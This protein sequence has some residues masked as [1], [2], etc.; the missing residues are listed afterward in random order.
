VIDSKP[1]HENNASA[2]EHKAAL[3]V[4]RIFTRVAHR[5]PRLKF[6]TDRLLKYARKFVVIY[7]IKRIKSRNFS[8]IASNCTG[9]LPYRFLDVPYNTPTINLFF[10]APDYMRFIKRLDYYLSL[11][12][13]FRDHSRYPEAEEV[14]KKQGMHPIGVLD[15]IEIHFMHYQSEADAKRKW[16]RRKKRINPEHLVFAFTDKDLCT[17]DLLKEFDELPY[18]NKFVFTANP[19]HY[20][21]HCIAVP[22]F[23]GQTEIGDAYTNYD[24]LMHVNFAKLIGS[25]HQ[26][27]ALQTKQPAT[28]TIEPNAPLPNRT[29][30]RQSGEQKAQQPIPPGASLSQTLPS[31]ITNIRVSGNGVR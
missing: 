10:M 17:P 11:P 15:D 14:R 16:N 20:L 7:R 23:A 13:T 9:T 12:L 27:I 28:L 8:V 1:Q 3:P 21:K 5:S 6:I 18:R 31:E 22:D 24:A 4:Q 2:I 19:H 30:L 29:R 26:K 25:T